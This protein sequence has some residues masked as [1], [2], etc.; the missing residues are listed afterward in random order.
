MRID[1]SLMLT[2]VAAFVLMAVVSYYIPVLQGI[3]K[4]TQMA[5]AIEPKTIDEFVKLHYPKA[6]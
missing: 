2:L 1:W 4:N 5:A 6:S 3:K